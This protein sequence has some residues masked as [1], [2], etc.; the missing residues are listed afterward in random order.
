[1]GDTGLRGY[2]VNQ[3]T[4]RARFLGH[5]EARTRPLRILFT[6]IGAV[7]F[8]DAGDA[9]PVIGDFSIKHGVGGGV[10]I[11]IPQL[12]PLVILADWAFALNGPAPGWPGQFSMG[13][14]QVF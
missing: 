8:W 4:G 12:D 2:A 10:R 5:I 7:A 14:Y 6:R 3:Y 1:G 13:A 9:A 11:V